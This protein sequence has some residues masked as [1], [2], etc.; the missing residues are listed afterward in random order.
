MLLTETPVSAI[1]GIGPAYADKLSTYG[2]TTLYD[3]VNTSPVLVADFTGIS[4]KLIEHWRSAAW[5]LEAEGMHPQWAEAAVAG[6]VVTPELWVDKS[7]ADIQLLFT[8]AIEKGI[9]KDAP[10]VE[11]IFAITR[12]LAAIAY[13]GMIQGTVTDADGA[14]LAG[15]LVD[16]GNVHTLTNAK[17]QWRMAGIT[18]KSACRIFF[19]G[20]GYVTQSAESVPVQPGYMGAYQFTTVLQQGESL[21]LVWDVFNGDK[22]PVLQDYSTKEIIKGFADM[23]QGDLMRV[24]FFYVNGDIKLY[25]V[26]RSMINNQLCMHAFRVPPSVFSR[27]PA[28]GQY[29]RYSKGNLLLT[30]ADDGSALLYN[31][32]YRSSAQVQPADKDWNTVLTSFISV[33]YSIQ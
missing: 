25:S 12:Q 33:T 8:R 27:T 18:G 11:A 21:P 10:D 15:I 26:N 29:W 24:G 22:L 20:E 3:L 4:S 14:P 23:R 7:L 1:E 13:G 30:E 19:S 6:G 31:A 16:R 5:L 2:I 9:I 32:I 17:G 28:E